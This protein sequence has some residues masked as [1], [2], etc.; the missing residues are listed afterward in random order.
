MPGEIVDGNDVLAVRDAVAVA[1][2]RA[3]RGDGPTLLEA[4]TLPSARPLDASQLPRYTRPAIAQQ[5]EERDPLNRFERV[6][7][8]FGVGAAALDR[9]RT[10]ADVARAAGRSRC[11]ADPIADVSRLKTA[12]YAPHARPQ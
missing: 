9:A 8:D 7:R 4:K 3:R 6:L 1:V 2:A 12:V 11:R 10:D 5:W